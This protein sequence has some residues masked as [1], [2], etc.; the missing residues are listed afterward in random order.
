M[1]SARFR[2]CE[3]L[4]KC[5]A[6]AA[7]LIAR[8]AY[9]RRRFQPFDSLRTGATRRAFRR[10]AAIAS[11]IDSLLVEAV[12]R[13]SMTH[14]VSTCHPVGASPCAR[15][16]ARLRSPRARAPQLAQFQH[17]WSPQEIATSCWPNFRREVDFER[18]SSQRGLAPL[19]G[20]L[21]K[22]ATDHCPPSE[23]RRRLLTWPSKLTGRLV[24][25]RLRFVVD[26]AKFAKSAL[27]C[28]AALVGR[29]GRSLFCM[30]DWAGDSRLMGPGIDLIVDAAYP[31][32]RAEELAELSTDWAVDI[33]INTDDGRG[34]VR[35]LCQ[36]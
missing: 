17:G 29:M 11:P 27:C 23:R 28:V 36:Q 5:G 4:A 6:S 2:P 31:V 12:A 13:A 25:D 26:S 14:G 19:V 8:D 34:N 7:N 10:R 3:A 20:A 16:N 18:K 24:A 1:L 35:K 32:G 21:R 15:R 9:L 22:Q 33:M 30:T